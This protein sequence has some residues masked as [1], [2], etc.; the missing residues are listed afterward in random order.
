MIRLATLALIAPLVAPPAAWATPE[1]AMPVIC[2]PA[3]D[4]TTPD[5]LLDNLAAAVHAGGPIDVLAIGSASTIV[6]GKASFPYRMIEVLKEALPHTTFRLSVEGARGLSAEQLLE[7][8]RAALARRH[9]QLVLWQTGTVEAVRGTNPDELSDVLVEG[10]A[11]VVGQG[12]NLILIDP[13]FSRFLRANTDLSPYEQAMHSAAMLP[14][15]NLFHRFD[16][17]HDWAEQGL[18]D[19]ERVPPASQMT[20]V[21][22]LHACIGRALAHFVL[23]GI[24]Q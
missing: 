5:Q 10:A 15:A 19:L 23:H 18:L 24:G 8:L 1:Q 7:E 22:T 20:A 14:G 16:L 13:Q 4:N 6:A 21:T 3:G 9:Y 12:G 2:P 17:M 11:L